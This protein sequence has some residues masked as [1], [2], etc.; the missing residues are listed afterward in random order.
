MRSPPLVRHVAAC[1]RRHGVSG[2]LVVAVSGGPDSVALVRALV[3]LLPEGS[4]TI[5][6]LNHQL[7]GADSDA[8]EEFVRR[9]HATLQPAGVR[10]WCQRLDVAAGAAGGNLEAAARRLRYDWLARVA[11][12]AAAAWVATGHTAE[13]VLHRLIRG[14]GLGGLRAIAERR[15]LAPGIRLVRPLLTVRRA[16]VLDY[17]RSLGQPYREDRSNAD[18]RY[19]RNRIR[20]ELLP[21]LAGYNPAIASVLTRLAR[22]AAEVDRGQAA[23]ARALLAAAERPRA[24]AVLVFDRRPLARASRHTVRDM[25]RL[26]WR[27]AGWPQGDMSFAAWDRLAA[28]ALGELA[29]VDLPGGIHA[30]SRPNVVQLYMK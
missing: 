24:G 12:D 4:V 14:T 3:A 5:A 11:A 13:T 8:D 30:R 25:F 29:A 26:V 20:H 16:E 9:L 21:L 19:T 7:R 1:L 23:A 22:Q 10:L 2:S 27:R 18:L 15:R 6:H 17:L 28:V